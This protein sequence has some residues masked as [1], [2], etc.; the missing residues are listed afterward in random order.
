MK[1]RLRRICAVL[2]AAIIALALAWAA[3][4]TEENDDDYQTRYVI[5]N[6]KSFVNVRSA[7]K[8]NAQEV[9]RLECGDVVYTLGEKKGQYV[10]IYTTSFESTEGWIHRG[11]LV[12]EKPERTGGKTYTVRAKGRVALRRY[13]NGSRRAWINPGKTVEVYVIAGEWALTNRG[14]IRTEYLEK[15]EAPEAETIEKQGESGYN[16]GK[17]ANV[18]TFVKGTEKDGRGA[19]SAGGDPKQGYSV[20]C[21]RSL[22]DAGREDGGNAEGMAA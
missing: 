12:E 4:G 9:G 22:C 5:C 8:K 11:Y 20:A 21:G 16:T 15:Q 1:D 13:V 3:A 6:P 19:V 14:F 2:C 18:R 10:K 17:G 7:A